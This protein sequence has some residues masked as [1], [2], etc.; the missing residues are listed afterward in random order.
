MGEVIDFPE[1][2]NVQEHNWFMYHCVDCGIPRT[3]KTEAQSCT[4]ENSV[5]YVEA[6]MEE[7]EQ[8][9]LYMKDE[10]KY[11]PTAADKYASCPLPQPEIILLP[12]PVQVRHGFLYV[13]GT[14]ILGSFAAIVV[15]ILLATLLILAIT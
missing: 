4:Y 3:A 1:R 7:E 9:E 12:Q 15:F 8:I 2:V 10:S 11:I 5:S 6:F 14:A 13:L